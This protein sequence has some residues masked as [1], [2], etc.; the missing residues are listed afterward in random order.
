MS[1]GFVSETQLDDERKARQDEWERVRKPDDPAVAPELE[2]CNKS[3]FDQ[4]KE[5][6]DKKQAEID[7]AKSFKN[8]IRGVDEDEADF[9]A[10][11]SKKKLEE[12]R[13]R[14]QEEKEMLATLS[15]TVIP[16][17]EPTLLRPPV[18]STKPVENK[19]ARLLV[20]AVK[21]KTGSTDE[22]TASK[23][24][25]KE[26]ETSASG[27]STN[28]ESPVQKP[29]SSLVAYGDYSDSEGDGESN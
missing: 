11:V 4:L 21:R 19:Q 26:Q 20:G 23:V 5:N 17:I 16:A 14:K 9:L 18:P 8:M 2:V 22:G 24:T 13:R 10:M 7:E 6:K 15:N 27:E 12:E 1:S 29:V 3:L 28:E 25:K